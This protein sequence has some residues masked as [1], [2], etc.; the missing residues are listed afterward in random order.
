MPD[1]NPAEIIGFQ[2]NLFSYSL[3][4]YLVTDEIWAKSREDMGYKK[5]FK[6]KLMYS[7]SGKPYIDLRMSF[8]YENKFKFV[9]EQLEYFI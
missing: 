1:W 8:N 4:K 9:V 2:P 7:F 6:P 5:L 3:Y